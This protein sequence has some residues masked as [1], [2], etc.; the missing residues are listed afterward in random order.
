MGAQRAN[1]ITEAE[2]VMAKQRATMVTEARQYLEQQQ[3]IA[4]KTFMEQQEM[5]SKQHD[6]Y[7][8]DH[9]HHKQRLQ[10]ISYELNHAEERMQVESSHLR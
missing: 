8:L 5:A 6:E 3:A 10:A 9:E 2:S 7:Y 4:N 1:L